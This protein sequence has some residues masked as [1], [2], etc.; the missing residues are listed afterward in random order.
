MRKFLI[1][2]FSIYSL[3]TACGGC[4]DSFLATT[5]EKAITKSYDGLDKSL[6]N[7]IKKLKD[8]IGKTIADE[9]YSRDT[10][11]KNTILDANKLL[12]LEQLKFTTNI[13][14]LLR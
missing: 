11:M 12:E 5:S 4:I 10:L 9:T 6:E 13:E 8:L 7:R 3:A 14:R 2:I 1:L